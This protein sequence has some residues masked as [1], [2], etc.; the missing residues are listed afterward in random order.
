MAQQRKCPGCGTAVGEA[1][2]L[3]VKCGTHLQTGAKVAAPPP[4]GPQV[5]QGD[6]DEEKI[7][8]GFRVKCFLADIFP[9]LFDW[10]VAVAA[11]V[12]GIPGLAAIV[13]GAWMSQQGLGGPYVAAGGFVFYGQALA[14]LL[15]G[16][17]R[18][19]PHA[20][21]DFSG[22]K[23]LVFFLLLTAPA[24]YGLAMAKANR[25]KAEEKRK[26]MESE[27]ADFLRAVPRPQ[28]P[29]RVDTRAAV[30]R[31][32]FARPLVR[33]FPPRMSRTGSGVGSLAPRTV[34][35]CGGAARRAGPTAA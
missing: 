34:P 13:L 21:G 8:F 25:K 16:E 12:L 4:A 18:V 6:D 30:R 28:L 19:L 26:Q 15:D 22:T 23:W 29:A 9:G 32:E 10:K 27:D 31:L 1:D 33:P 20:L 7:T 5:R 3:C 2:V 14:F 35:G 24:T 17:R 11:A